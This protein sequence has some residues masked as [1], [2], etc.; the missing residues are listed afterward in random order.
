MLA[1]RN[2]DLLEGKIQGISSLDI[3]AL[4]SKIK[5][6]EAQINEVQ[7]I[8]THRK[9][10]DKLEKSLKKTGKCDIFDESLVQDADDLPE[11]LDKELINFD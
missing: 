8:G 11:V 3:N 10:L 2:K 5:G 7:V 1:D 6:I 4:E 9:G